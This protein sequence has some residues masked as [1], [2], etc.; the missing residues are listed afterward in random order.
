[1]KH[2][3]NRLRRMNTSSLGSQ[4]SPIISI[5][6]C[7]KQAKDLILNIHAE[8]NNGSITYHE[9]LEKLDT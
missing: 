2:S 4:Q 1:M 7:R 3:W 5:C 8:I 9:K 6:I